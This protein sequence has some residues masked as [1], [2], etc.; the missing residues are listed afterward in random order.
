MFIYL[1]VDFMCMS[2][3]M[4]SNS[5]AATPA[6]LVVDD[7]LASTRRYGRWLRQGGWA[8]RTAPVYAT[9]E[10]LFEQPADIVLL[11]ERT[12]RRYGEAYVVGLL[13]A[14]A[15]SEL[16]V[17][18]R[19]LIGLT[20]LVEGRVTFVAEPLNQH[21]LLSS[22]ADV[23]DLQQYER[24]ISAYFT[25]IHALVTLDPDVDPEPLIEEALRRRADA[26]EALYGLD[27]RSC[28]ERFSRSAGSQ[29]VAS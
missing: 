17:L 9:L 14:A 2:S 3:K 12:V 23:A 28:F 11:H 18:V 6:V 24:A 27:F 29:P 20:P 16:V 21:A 10:Q 5:R 26:D 8:V 1:N 7:G 19:D 13:Q 15:S 4:T 22:V 25:S